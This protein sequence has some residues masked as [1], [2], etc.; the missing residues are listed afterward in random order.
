[1]IYWVDNKKMGDN[2]LFSTM[3]W[4]FS[5]REALMLFFPDEGKIEF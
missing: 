3:G 1:M 5:L 2:N 4:E